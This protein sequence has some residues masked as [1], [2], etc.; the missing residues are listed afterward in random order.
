MAALSTPIPFYIASEGVAAVVAHA[1][2]DKAMWE[3][4][5][6]WVSSAQWVDA[7]LCMA[8]EIRPY[9]Q[10]DCG[11]API[12]NWGFWRSTRACSLETFE[13]IMFQGVRYTWAQSKLT[14]LMAAKPPRKNPTYT[15]EWVDWC[16]KVMQLVSC[17]RYATNLSADYLPA[18]AVWNADEKAA[19]DRTT[20]DTTY[21]LR[22]VR[23]LAPAAERAQQDVMSTFPGRVGPSSNP[24]Q[25]AYFY[26][27]SWLLSMVQPK[28]FNYTRRRMSV[29]QTQA[30]FEP[31]VVIAPTEYAKR[32]GVWP[33]PRYGGGDRGL[34]DPS[35]RSVMTAWF[36]RT[37]GTGYWWRSAPVPS[38]FRILPVGMGSATDV[39]HTDSV[40]W[41]GTADALIRMCEGWA[42]DVMST[43]F[44]Q[45]V[46]SGLTE[47]LASFT[48][49]PPELRG[50]ANADIAAMRD[51]ITATKCNE[52]L[53]AMAAGLGAAAS[54]AAAINPVA[55]AI[56]G[57][58]GALVGLL[59]EL[60]KATGSLAF[61]GAMF[62]SACLAS[63]VVRG[64]PT[65][66]TM[67][68]D[69]DTRDARMPDVAEKSAL[70][71][72]AAASGMPTDVWFDAARA[73]EGELDES[74]LPVVPGGDD[75]QTASSIT[76]YLVVGGALLGGAVLWKY[77]KR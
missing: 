47:F 68:C 35:P 32:G 28:D 64:I 43:S 23:P 34:A 38:V 12:C 77:L 3:W 11:G 62:E 17:A 40:L 44:G 75:V 74:E 63:P 55:G 36:S 37:L 24:A 4:D 59:G 72:E 26:R 73:A 22:N 69:F 2:A 71:A 50:L 7:R 54:I 76:P 33:W 16:V 18:Y 20:R 67:A 61:G 45:A 9:N 39:T 27:D 41:Y 1:V 57:I 21:G 52:A 49:V 31:S 53:G 48:L 56:V 29:P 46:S 25:G 6:R 10:A 58:F 8:G 66:G 5:K 19:R 60:L 13:D 15:A 42:E 14:E 65:E 30:H 70:V 51:A